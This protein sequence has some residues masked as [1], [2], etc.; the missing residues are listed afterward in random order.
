MTR[1]NK[2]QAGFSLLELMISVLVLVI[3][4]GAVFNQINSLQKSTKAESLKL[5]LTQEN[6]EFIDQFSRDLHM[7]GYPA[8][9]MYSNYQGRTDSLAASG[10]VFV[11]TTDLIFEGDVYGNGQVFRVEYKYFP[12]DPND[13]HC[14][15]IR[16]SVVPKTANDPL[17]GYPNPPYY[18]EVQ[19]VIDPTGMNEPLFTYF[20]ASGAEVVVNANPCATP[21]PLNPPPAPAAG[22]AD[23]VTNTALIQQIDAI[24]VNLNTRSREFDPQTRRQHVN[25][26]S[27]IAEL[28]N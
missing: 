5:D 17:T 20:E 12:N 19:D 27:A 13:P 16:R 9:K 11:S 1:A 15:C 22:C 23:L 14:P 28:E 7:S 24:K 18:T 3:V 25:S 26:L 2:R 8:P 21:A 10:L 6:R 4:M